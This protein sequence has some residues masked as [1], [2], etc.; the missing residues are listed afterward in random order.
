MS[1]RRRPRPRRRAL[2]RGVA[3]LLL[4]ALV[5]GAS[6]CRR[7]RERSLARLASSDP[8]VRSA[9]LESLASTATDADVGALAAAARDPNPDVRRAA[10]LA[11][12]KRNTSSAVDRVGEALGDP[13]PTV[14]QTAIAAL[15]DRADDDKARA[16][17][18]SAYVRRGPGV[19]E[20]IVAAL[21]RRGVPPAEVVRGEA[22]RLW[23]RN[24]VAL[25]SG[26]LAERAGAAE[27]LGRSGRQEVLGILG[28]RL[29]DE[30]ALVAAAAARGLGAAGN[31]EAL[32][33][34]VGLLGDPSPPVRD[35][36]IDALG[37]LGDPHAL[38][39][40]AAVAS[41][42]SANA[43]RAARSLAAIPGS[44]EAACE[45]AR[46]VQ[47]AAVFRVLVE[48]ARGAGAPCE[49][50]REGE[51]PPHRE[52][53]ARAPGDHAEEDASRGQ[54]EGE[55]RLDALLRQV[56]A[57]RE[58]QAG[59]RDGGG[60]DRPGQIRALLF[61]DR[62]EVRAEAA[63]MLEERPEPEARRMLEALAEADYFVEV[64]EA[65]AAALRASPSR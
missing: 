1:A 51:G 35:A 57:W 18:L 32:P 62:P 10:V 28:A 58:T 22:E 41:A 21:A 30:S 40:L 4:A 3:T 2:A 37:T 60:R 52:G 63:R 23:E 6:G 16:W 15:A 45:A 59:R 47:D 34:L 54:G 39:P 38:E 43:L 55:S 50:D 27:E 48:H 12:G 44:G 9:A 5:V 56:A 14:Q 64:R 46:A 19:R 61:H 13:D 8:V 53:R 17:L 29:S 31:P 49:L 20:A 65:A 36:A 42:G 11:L 33:L 24:L 7:D 26:S 25:E